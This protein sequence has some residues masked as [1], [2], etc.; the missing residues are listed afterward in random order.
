VKVGLGL[1]LEMTNSSN[2]GQEYSEWEPI[3]KRSLL[4]ARRINGDA[5]VL[6]AMKS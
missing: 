4:S 1:G 3:K 6:R 2:T 5:N